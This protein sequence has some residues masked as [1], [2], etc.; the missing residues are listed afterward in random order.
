M[1]N[2]SYSLAEILFANIIESH[3]EDTAKFIEAANYEDGGK[4][5]A[6]KNSDS[7]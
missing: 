4:K 5:A 7:I 3:G 1:S 2:E 6:K